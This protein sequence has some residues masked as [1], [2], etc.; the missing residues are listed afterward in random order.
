ML[1]SI[2]GIWHKLFP[3]QSF[4]LNELDLKLESH[5]NEKNGF[6]VEVGANDGIRQSNTLYF[7]KYKEWEGLLIEAIPKLAAECRRNRPKCIVENAALVAADY[8][9]EIVEMHYCDLMS[10]V[11]G[12]LDSKEQEQD[13]LEWGSCFLR[14]NESPHVVK[15]PARTLSDVL[16][17]HGIDQFD[18]L[19]LDVE[20]YEAEVLRGLDFD[21]HGP[22]YMLIEVWESDK[23]DLI[24]ED[25]YRPLAVLAEKNEFRDVLYEKL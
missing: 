8:P 24:V 25:Y 7:E 2:R 15:A 1:D 21:R 16:D 23:I 12:G 19:S 10:V 14:S 4:A 13:H 22:R 5:V 18:L 9:R 20:G 17:K 3:R 11:K 6:F